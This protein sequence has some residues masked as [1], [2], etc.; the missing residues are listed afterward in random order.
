MHSVWDEVKEF[1]AE[2]QDETPLPNLFVP[3]DC[4]E[5][6]DVHATFQLLAT[7]CRT[8]AAAG[9]LLQMIQSLPHHA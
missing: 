7:A 2:G 4:H 5:P 6:E 1:Q 9:R 8:V 3:F